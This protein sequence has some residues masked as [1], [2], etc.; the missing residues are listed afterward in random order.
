[1]QGRF[2]SIQWRFFLVM[3]MF[4]GLLLSQDIHAQNVEKDST[5]WVGEW[6]D[7]GN[8]HY[9]FHLHLYPVGNG[10]MTG[11]FEWKLIWTSLLA[12]KHKVG[13]V[14]IEY[15]VGYY[16]PAVKSLNMQGMRQKD[17]ADIISMDTYSVTILEEGKT[18]AGIN[19]KPGNYQG[20]LYGQLVPEKKEVIA[21]KQY[22][23]VDLEP[24]KPVTPKKPIAAIPEPPAEKP[25]DKLT[26]EPKVP[27]AAP[28]LDISS[29]ISELEKSAKKELGEREIIT[30]K[31]IAT[32]AE[33]LRIQIY[34][35]S[36]VDGDVISVIW[37]G[38]WVLRYYKVVKA[39]KMLVLKLKSG[40][41]TLVMH[42]ENLGRYPPNTA[43]INFSHGSKQETIILNSTMGKSE[44]L[45]FVK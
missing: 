7:D 10:K 25:I 19:R 20:R 28:K 15:L 14:A 13:S 26:T 16:N 27:V 2:P 4:L 8:L 17:P 31:S 38:E 22:D 6:A 21:A 1:M 33:N 30:K 37:N 24:V 5:H 35:N 41:N 45:K 44:A 43:A 32:S 3:T 40:E 23:S 9:A 36:I 18:M 12:H 11:Y 29:Q 34:D 42:A 39:P